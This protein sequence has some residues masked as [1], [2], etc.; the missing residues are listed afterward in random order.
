MLKKMILLGILSLNYVFVYAWDPMESYHDAITSGIKVGVPKPENEK[1]M[2]Q[3]HD[4]LEDIRWTDKKIIDDLPI[5]TIKAALDLTETLQYEFLKGELPTRDDKGR[6]RLE[7][8]L[9]KLIE[10]LN[11]AKVMKSTA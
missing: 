4:L 9:A 3:L 10:E 2:S 11:F 7:W 1:R 8:Y 6:D 5:K